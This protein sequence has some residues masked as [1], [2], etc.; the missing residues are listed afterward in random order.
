MIFVKNHQGKKTIAQFCYCLPALPPT[1]KTQ[2]V[3]PV[4]PALSF[5]DPK[6]TGMLHQMRGRQRA[7][8]ATVAQ[9]ESFNKRP[10]TKGRCYFWNY[11][12]KRCNEKLTAG[13]DRKKK[14]EV[15]KE[16]K[17]SLVSLQRSCRKT[18]ENV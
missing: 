9:W 2:K 1:L 15:A 7:L 16:R 14:E 8:T 4:L 12:G 5:C 18:F 17:A 11:H 10:D 13:P 6:S 3:V